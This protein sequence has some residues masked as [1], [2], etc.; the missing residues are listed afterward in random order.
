MGGMDYVLAHDHSA[1]ARGLE[2][3]KKRQ[4]ERE[5]M[6]GGAPTRCPNCGRG[7]AEHV[8]REMRACRAALRKAKKRADR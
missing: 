2:E 3:K 6:R 4:K 1:F 8:T 5:A 7:M